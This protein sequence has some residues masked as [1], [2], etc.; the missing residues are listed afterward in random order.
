M[1]EE[2]FN[3]ANNPPL[4]TD[5]S[6]PPNCK[7]CHAPYSEQELP[8]PVGLSACGVCGQGSVPDFLFTTVQPLAE[9]ATVGQGC[10]LRAVVTRSRKKCAGEVCAKIVS[11]YLPFMEYELH[12]QLLAKLKLKAMNMLCGLKVGWRFVTRNQVQ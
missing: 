1:D 3:H 5:A 9:L 6:A 11:D 2:F 4:P 10:V 7:L 8:F 12:R